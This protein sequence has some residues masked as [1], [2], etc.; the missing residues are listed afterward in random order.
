MSLMPSGKGD[1]ASA[2]PT[3]SLDLAAKDA[4]THS[5]A[6][7]APFPKSTN[8]AEAAMNLSDDDLLLFCVI[9]GETESFSIGCY[10]VIVAQS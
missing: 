4:N 6:S 1:K 10:T 5:T 2:N 3:Q 7:E 9:E 8:Q